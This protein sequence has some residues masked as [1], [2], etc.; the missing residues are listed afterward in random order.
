VT[1]DLSPGRP[2]DPSPERLDS[3]KDIASYLKRDVSTAQRWEKRE[4]MPVHR[5]QHDKMGSVY[6]FPAELDAW[7]RSRQLR[8]AANGASQIDEPETARNRPELLPMDDRDV[9]PASTRRRAWL[10]GTIAV[11]TLALAVFVLLERAEFFWQNPLADARFVRLTEFE[12]TER[13]AAISRDGR[14]VAF[15][16]DRDG[17]MDVW[18]TQVGTGRFHNLTKGKVT[19]LGNPDVRTIGFSPDDALVTLWRRTPGTPRPGSIA[20]LSVPTLGGEP[21]VFIEGAAELD[22]SNDGRRLVYHTTTAGDPTFIRD[23]TSG[24]ERKIFTAPSGLHSHYPVWSPDDEYIY[25]VYGSVPNDMDIWRIA[26]TGAAAERITS[27][28]SRVSHP[29]F[30]T[31]RTLLYLASGPD[32]SGP[33]L[34]AVDVKR[35][36]TH[37]ISVGV[38]RYTSLSTTSDGRR[39]VV[40]VANSKRSLWRMPIT[41][42]VA[43]EREVSRIKLPTT[44]GR[45]PRFGSGYIL[46]VSSANDAD[47]IIKLADGNGRPLWSVEGGH[48]LGAP[49]IAPDGRRIAFAVEDRG[50]KRMYVMSADDT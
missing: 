19:E 50:Q 22:W 47:S 16:S 11:T 37:R 39:I 48:V 5:H 3:W 14:Y 28:N 8:L 13:A 34:H 15:L 38:E 4:G 21:D 23:L 36:D 30:L 29:A 12:G 6:A 41:N 18:L 40:T 26:A 27:H 17:P 31:A 32:G 42:A 35:R 24:A 43:T 9:R 1:E 44:H 7:W 45:S 33:W 49:A 20:V 10:I 46:Y 2:P 25:F